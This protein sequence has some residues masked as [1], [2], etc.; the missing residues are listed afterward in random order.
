MAKVHHMVFLKFKRGITEDRL[1]DVFA[2]LANLQ[3]VIAGIEYFQ[4][5]PY[6]SSEGLNKGFDYGFLMTFKSVAARDA[7][8]PH[9]AHLRVRDLLLTLIDDVIAVD[10]ED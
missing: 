8:L 6:S 10:I 9:P 1:A 7:Y 5:G 2:Q 3:E 4:A